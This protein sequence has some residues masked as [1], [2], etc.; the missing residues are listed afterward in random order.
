MP[1][2][3]HK[4]KPAAPIEDIAAGVV[5]RIKILG[6]ELVFVLALIVSAAAGW[7]A[8]QPHESGCRP[9]AKKFRLSSSYGKAPASAHFLFASSRNAPDHCFRAQCRACSRASSTSVGFP[10]ADAPKDLLPVAARTAAVA[11]M[12]I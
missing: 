6:A 7:V 11:S 5:P 3:T 8:K 12:H 10:A 2:F 9:H 1:S 4:K